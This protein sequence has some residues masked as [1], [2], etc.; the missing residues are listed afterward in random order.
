MCV[1]RPLV[2][3][4]LPCLNSSVWQSHPVVLSVGKHGNSGWKH[5][6]QAHREELGFALAAGGVVG[7]Y[8]VHCWEHAEQYG[9]LHR[10]LPPRAALSRRH[11]S[12]YGLSYH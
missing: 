9:A 6:E 1:R 8:L 10:Q 4:A 5:I 11:A 2:P 3:S 12:M 7:G